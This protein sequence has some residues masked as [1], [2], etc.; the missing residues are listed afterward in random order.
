MSVSSPNTVDA[1][2]LNPWTANQLLIYFCHFEVDDHFTMPA[3]DSNGQVDEEDASESVQSFGLDQGKNDPMLLGGSAK[4]L[5]VASRQSWLTRNNILLFGL[6]CGCC[7][8]LVMFLYIDSQPKHEIDY[9][10]QSMTVPLRD[11][12][13]QASDQAARAKVL[14]PRK[15][16]DT[17]A[18][19]DGD[20]WFSVSV[21]Q[22]RAAADNKAKPSADNFD[23]FSTSQR[24]AVPLLTIRRVGSQ[25]TLVLNKF[26][27]FQDHVRT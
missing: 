12:V 24:S 19:A 16:Y 11:A 18:I 23:P 7:I 21:I 15:V 9:D 14:H 4:V 1:V 3:V 6:F 10:S 17:I 22:E 25:H 8:A 27:V 26:N 2:A 20:M 5:Q 13:R